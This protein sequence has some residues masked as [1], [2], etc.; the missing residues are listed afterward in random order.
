M[1]AVME[2]LDAN[3]ELSYDE[4]AEIIF[5]PGYTDSDRASMA[6]AIRSPGEA[7]AFVHGGGT[8][9]ANLWRYRYDRDRPACR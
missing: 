1:R 8:R 6:R 7:R 2:T 5:G 9:S 3:P 4:L